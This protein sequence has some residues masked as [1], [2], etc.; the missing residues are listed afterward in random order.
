MQHS[1]ILLLSVSLM[2]SCSAPGIAQQTRAATADKPAYCAEYYGCI[3]SRP[4]SETEARSSRGY[5]A[6]LPSQT[7]I[8]Y[9]NP[10]SLSGS[11]PEQPSPTDP[12]AH[13]SPPRAAF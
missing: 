10:R 12:S 13:P 1:R 5:P 9:R 6:P 8:A 3:E 4:L 2:A 7:D 11:G